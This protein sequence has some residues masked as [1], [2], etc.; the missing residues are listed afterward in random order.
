MKTVFD[1]V[2][3]SFIIARSL[4][5]HMRASVRV[6]RSADQLEVPRHRWE[7]APGE[8]DDALIA[9]QSSA[10]A[11]VIQEVLL[12]WFGAQGVLPV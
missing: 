3:V 12:T 8:L 11:A 7:W 9:D 5:G 2:V 1:T 10:A 6:S 4:D